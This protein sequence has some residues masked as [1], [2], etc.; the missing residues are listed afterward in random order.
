MWMM[1]GA[2]WYPQVSRV[3]SATAMLSPGLGQPQLLSPLQSPGGDAARQE[4][5]FPGL[6]I[7]V[8]PTEP[9]GWSPGQ[10]LTALVPLSFGVSISV[11]VKWQGRDFCKCLQDSGG[12]TPNPWFFTPI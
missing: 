9:S 2:G 11:R 1:V 3:C 7:G 8:S 6:F 10:Q 12:N 5:P 4:A